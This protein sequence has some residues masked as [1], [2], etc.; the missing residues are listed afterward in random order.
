MRPNRQAWLLALVAG[1]G[2]LPITALAAQ[3]PPA[4]QIP[5]YDEGRFTGVGFLVENDALLRFAN[6]DQNYTGA[7]GLQWSGGFIDGARLTAPLALVDR[8]TRMER[9][10]ARS[11]MRMHGLQLIG[12]AFTPDSLNTADVIPEDRPYGS[13]LGLTVR[14]LTVRDSDLAV[15]WSSDLTLGVLGLPLAREVQTAIHR[16][17]RGPGESR[18]YDPLGWH[19]Q[20][21]DGGE[22]TLLYRATVERLAFGDAPNPGE[23]KHLQGTVGLQ[24]SAGYYTNIAALATVR[25]GWFQSEFWEF[26]GGGSSGTASGVGNQ[27]LAAAAP[28][29]REAYLFGGVRPRLVVYNALLQGQFRQ[30]AHSFSSG[31]VER[32]VLEFDGGVAVTIPIRRHALGVVLTATGRTPE[33]RAELRRTHRWG[34]VLITW[35]PPPRSLEG[36]P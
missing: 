31:E 6:N 10:H 18:P 22:P 4:E 19:N 33:H 15:A 34:S 21:S 20:I 36:Q 25:A 12:T 28:H 5:P 17:L 16:A 32:T 9:V 23:R 13:I 3:A 11:P 35:S 26:G 30:S 24:G 2:W 27:R 1:C 7:F 14:R 29:R 8:L